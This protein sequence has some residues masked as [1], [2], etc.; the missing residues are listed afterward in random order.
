MRVVTAQM[1][2]REIR[3]YCELGTEAEHLLERA[4]AEQGLSART[5]VSSKWRA[6]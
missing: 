3:E 1:G 5:T 4:I 2:L 6:R